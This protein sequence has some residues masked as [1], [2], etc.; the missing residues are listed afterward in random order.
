MGAFDPYWK[1]LGIPPA[2]QPPNL[3]RLLGVG[4]F[5]S[6]PEVIA[7]A[8]DR[9]MMHVRSYQGGRYSDLS[10]KLLNELAAARVC[11]LDPA[12]K[13]AYD[14][15]LR[16]QLHNQPAAEAASRSASLPPAPPVPPVVQT[17]PALP[18]SAA[19]PLG[20]ASVAVAGVR[21][22]AGTASVAASRRSRR[23]SRTRQVALLSVGVLLLVALGLLVLVASDPAAVRGSNGG[24]A[25]DGQKAFDDLDRRDSASARPKPSRRSEGPRKPRVTA[26]QQPGSNNGPMPDLP[27]LGPQVETG[28]PKEPAQPPEDSPSKPSPPKP[29]AV[30]QARTQIAAEFAQQLAQAS[31]PDEKMALARM[32]AAE[33]NKAADQPARA[34]ALLEMA[35]QMAVDLADADEALLAIDGLAKQFAVDAPAMKAAALAQI[36]QKTIAAAR[37]KQ[38]APRMTAVLDELLAGENLSAAEQLLSALQHNAVEALDAELRKEAQNRSEQFQRWKQ[39]YQLIEQARQT[40]AQNPDDQQAHLLLGQYYCF[41]KDDWEQG[42]KHLARCGDPL[43]RQVAAAESA[44]SE[45]P[46]EQLKLADL[47]WEASGKLPAHY[48][49][50]ARQRAGYWYSRIKGQ[51]PE[52]QQQ[53]VNQRLDELGG[54][55]IDELS[56]VEG[57]QCRVPP[58]RLALLKTYGGTEAS[59][60]AVAKALEWI[61]AHRNAGGGWSFVHTTARCRTHCTDP[62]TTEAPNAATALAL[63]ALQGAGNSQNAGV[64]RRSVTDGLN[65]LKSRATPAGKNAACYYESGAPQL[66][67]HAWCTIALC[68]AARDPSTRKAAT[69][70]VWFILN[71]QNSDGGWGER[72]P[73]GDKPGTASDTFHTAW[74]VIA[75]RTAIWVKLFSAE[76]DTRQIE[77]AMKQAESFLDRVALAD[78]A[79]YRRS[80]DAAGKDEYATTAAI[81]SRMYLGWPQSHPELAAYAA[82]RGKSGAGA[83]G[84]YCLNWLDAQSLRELAGPLWL[85]WQADLRD[86]LIAAQSTDG[87]AA[88]SWFSNSGDWGNKLGGRLFCTALATLILEV[89]Y[90]NPPLYK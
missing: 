77:R 34:Y 29:E 5:E 20:A 43:L 28:G 4:L 74:N 72:P 89:Y 2:E 60:A 90:R 16:R 62:G 50:Q 17:A 53:L 71:T 9:Q 86:R 8:A 31:R 81:L 65:F 64:H 54:E 3:Y 84:R 57:L 36:A 33:G 88:G 70:A 85:S 49:Q 59:E 37:R 27:P 14:E 19:P 58:A 78:A 44:V 32:L 26:M 76:R 83:L 73:L 24:S 40:L 35:C 61:V 52:E 7:N 68:E 56:S 75:L 45:E 15:Q 63:L 67:A 80:L 13:A 12:K 6:D 39:Q 48:R 82:H 46:S 18:A 42:L 55:E 10:Q 21:G 11:L 51:L 22:T 23:N 79:G 66:P 69:A 38:L 41:V 30:E 25:S 1:W 47:W 87:H